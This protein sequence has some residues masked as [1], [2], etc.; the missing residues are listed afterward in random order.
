MP[1][2]YSTL[3]DHKQR[4]HGLLELPWISKVQRHL[5]DGFKV[6]GLTKI[7]KPIQVE[8]ILDIGCGLGEYCYLR[9]GKYIGIDNS[10]PRVRFARR[11]NKAFCF[12]QADALN[13]PFRDGSFDAVLLANSAHHLSDDEFVRVLT[14][15]KRVSRRY[16]ILDDCVKTA[17]QNRLSRF[18]YSLDRGT[19][20]RTIEQFE[21]I[22]ARDS[23]LKLVLRRTH[24]TFPGLYLHAVF[25]LERT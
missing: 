3:A 8:N 2:D 12:F 10:F 17:D 20:F 15:M 5:L 4:F 11:R 14:Q 21:S 23:N 22:L 19:M 18:F 9:K 6:S 16:L 7:L 25:I 1:N 13:L 24:R